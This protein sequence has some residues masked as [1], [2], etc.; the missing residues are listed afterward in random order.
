MLQEWSVLDEIKE[1]GGAAKVGE[2]EVKPGDVSWQALLGYLNFSEGRPDPRFQGQ[3][4]EAYRQAAQ[5]GEPVSALARVLREQLAQLR[6]SGASAFRKAEQVE[7]VLRLVFDRLLPAYRRHH[8]DLLAHLSD[9]DLFQPF[10]LARAFEAVLFQGGPW[11]QEER[12]INGALA[13]LNDFVGHRPI[14]VLET[15]P[16]GEPYDHERVRPV[17][18][19]IRGAGVANGRYHD[20]V[21]RAVE[22]LHATDPSLLAEAQLA[23]QL[24]DELAFDPRAYDHNHPANRRPNQVFGEW[25]PHHLDNQGRYRRMVVRQLILEALL[26]RVEHGTEGTTEERLEEAASVLAGVLLMASGTS[27]GSPTAY[28]SSMT[29]RVL[30]ERII[31]RYRD[32][33]YRHLLETTRGP[34]GE[35]LRQEAVA[36]RQPFGGA[37]Q[38]LNQYIAHHRAVQ[39]QERHLAVLFAEMGY[40]ESSRQ[41]AARI[42]TPALRLLSEILIRL[43]QGQLLAERGGLHEAAALLPEAEDL[44]NRGIHSGAFVDPWNILG[45]QG[46]YPLSAAREDSV[47]DPRIDELIDMVERLLDLH[48]RL[49][50]E[51]AAAGDQALKRELST[52][53]GR[54]AQW[55]DQFASI[56]VSDVRRVHGAEIADAAEHVAE[57]LARWHEQGEATA[58]PTFWREHLRDFHSPK[59][60]ALVVDALLRKHDYRASLALLM[61]WLGQ[62]EQA[63]LE[64]GDFSFHALALRWLLA[65]TR[66]DSANPTADNFGLVCKFF[67][68]LEANAD[69]NWHVPRLEGTPDKQEDEEDDE[70]DPYRAA[71]ED[72]TYRDST[73]DGQ[74]GALVDDAPVGKDFTLE[75]DARWIEKRLRFLSTV[76]RL[77]EIAARHSP[78]KADA[79]QREVLGG[80]LTRARENHK[81]LLSLLDAVH[82][83]PIPQPLGTHESLIEYDRRRV[84]KEQ[85]LEAAIGTCLDTALAVRA[86]QGTQDLTNAEREPG[87]AAQ[88]WEPLV[89]R[90]EQ[91]LMHGD[92]AEVR[93]ELPAFL[94][95][96]KTEPLLFVPLSSGGHPAAILRARLAQAVLQTLVEQMP[97]VGLLRETYHLLRAARAM[98]EAQPA[99]EAGRLTEFDRLFQIGFQGVLESVVESARA[100]EGPAV[101]DRA[102]VTLI[103]SVT[104][105]FLRLWVDYTRGVRL[106]SL[107][108]ID[109]PERFEELRSFIRTYGTDLFRAEFLTLANLR[110]VLHR[111]IEAYLD[112][113]REQE[114]AQRPQRLLADLGHTLPAELAV[115]SLKRV[116]RAVAENYDEY[117]DYK[118]TSTLSDYGENL[119]VLLDF[120]RLKTSYD[121]HSWQFRPL[122]LAHEVLAR[123]ERGEAALL[124]QQ[125][126]TELTRSLA[127]QHLEELARLEQSHALRLRTLADRLQE[128]FVKPLALDRLCVLVAPAMEAARRADDDGQALAR[129][130]EELQA[131]TATPTGIGLDV[132]LWLRRLQ[133]EVQRVRAERS[134][135]SGLTRK[136]F[137][138]PRVTLTLEE[139][140]RQLTEPE[141][142]ALGQS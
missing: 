38:N 103:E 132:P 63:P 124:W 126:V 69:E 39:Q 22:L 128:R 117:K 7:A 113:L 108:E 18:L 40:P 12:I 26:D 116:L 130:A 75:M 34:H 134:A 95:Q 80:W 44:L 28:D 24:L 86:L 55:W 137:M 67:D 57:A 35:R 101:T 93:R 59:A 73:D 53:M 1:C 70:E 32:A 140:Q 115:R 104:G 111:G 120:L 127:D 105:P 119:H 64:D 9:H 125:G 19:Y 87:A 114:D 133:R 58:G 48:S 20:L 37:R 13:R 89:L 45:F 106:S 107:E 78:R 2:S 8:A 122:V 50:G 51:A 6:G 76:A 72:V 109:S 77:W 99:E 65:A 60:F 139:V 97:R 23:P 71:Y 90:L 3:L 27:G 14:A 85:L 16:R 142:P 131:Q 136:H 123:G 66:S 92:A 29:F 30:V 25:D 36:L 94:E 102:L 135:I 21:A 31:P 141:P 88:T 118:H 49:L 98:E 15:R 41:H 96:F 5:L 138:A 121:R 43:A 4:N 110:G 84:L 10:F 47:R 91:A 46:L 100:W 79:K 68:Y 74:E 112:Y 33:F 129:F 54:L 82:D 81:R 61:N 52:R 42:P 62:A 17:P 11:S 83:S 56:S